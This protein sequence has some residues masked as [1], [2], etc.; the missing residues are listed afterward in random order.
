LSVVN[1]A[2]IDSGHYFILAE[3]LIKN[4]AQTAEKEYLC[5]NTKFKVN[6]E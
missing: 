3:N 2:E 5:S 1:T 6:H 4:L